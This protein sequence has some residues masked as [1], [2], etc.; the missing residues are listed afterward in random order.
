MITLL[1]GLSRDELGNDWM[2]HYFG[3]TILRVRAQGYDVEGADLESAPPI[4]SL[5]DSSDRLPQPAGIERRSPTVDRGSIPLL[6][7][8]GIRTSGLQES[9]A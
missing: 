6:E 3:P 1:Q 2:P 5:A 4:P 7:A 9:G 8:K